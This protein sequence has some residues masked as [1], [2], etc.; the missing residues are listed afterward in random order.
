MKEKQ[1]TALIDTGAD[2]SLVNKDLIKLEEDKIKETADRSRS[3]G[4]ML[5]RSLADVSIKLK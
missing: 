5:W 2:I 4:G 1:T 3:A